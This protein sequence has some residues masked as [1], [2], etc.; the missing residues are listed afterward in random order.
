MTEWTWV[1]AHG[2]A[3]YIET[4]L[5]TGQQG[6]DRAE[7]GQNEVK[8]NEELVEAAAGPILTLNGVVQN[9]WEIAWLAYLGV[10]DEH[11]DNQDER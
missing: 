10:V 2:S 3:N 11:D 7:N 9:E 8:G 6:Q 4:F 5:N 1:T